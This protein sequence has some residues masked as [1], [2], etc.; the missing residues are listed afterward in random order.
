MAKVLVVIDMQND[1]VYDA[2]KNEEAIKIVDNV[3]NEVASKVKDGYKVIF[4]RDTHDDNK[5]LSTYEGKHLPVKHCIKG[6][7][8]W[9][10]IEQLREFVTSDNVV[11][12]PNFGSR[13][14]LPQAIIE[15]YDAVNDH[16][17]E[18]EFIG[19]CTDICV[20]S[21]VLIAKSAFPET[22]ITVNS[23]CCAGLT[24]EKHE[25]ALDVMNSCQVTIL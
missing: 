24:P 19:V 15:S 17:E 18:I 12:K 9:E 21:N 25:A 4:T 16:L 7:D 23:S 11:D 6:T 14:E 2:L 13:M 8:G 20:V 10:I 3:Y 22:E 5:Y 1:F